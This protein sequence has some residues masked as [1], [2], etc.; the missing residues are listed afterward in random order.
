MKIEIKEGAIKLN[1]EEFIPKLTLLE[2]SDDVDGVRVIPEYE[3]YKLP[4]KVSSK[5]KALDLAR[6]RA[7]EIIKDEFPEARLS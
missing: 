6:E 2:S 1:D 4:K 3:N 7:E 5:D